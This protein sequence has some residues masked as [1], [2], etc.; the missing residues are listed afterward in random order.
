MALQIT[1]LKNQSR[2]TPPVSINSAVYRLVK[3]CS[4]AA[5]DY[6]GGRDNAHNAQP[7]NFI[8]FLFV[9]MEK[10]YVLNGQVYIEMKRYC[11]LPEG[12]G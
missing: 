9:V 4:D 1:C 10:H 12:E 6:K 7:N 3:N 8:D 5:F 11:F 2:E